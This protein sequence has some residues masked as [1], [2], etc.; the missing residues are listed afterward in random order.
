MKVGINITDLVPGKI[1]GMETYIRAL[2]H[3]FP[4]I[5]NED[6]F[7]VVGYKET[8]RTIDLNG[9]K[10]IPIKKPTTSEIRSKLL[11][12]I[13]IKNKFD[14]WFSPLLI[15]D[16]LDC[17]IPSVIKI[18]DMQHEYY[19]DFFSP[20]L[21]K[22]R[23]RY[24]QMSADNA[25]MILTV[26][27]KSRDDILKY[28][29]VNPKKVKIT[30]QNSPQWF[31]N[32]ISLNQMKL[33]KRNYKLPDQ[34]LFYPANS[35]KH[36]NHLRLLKAFSSVKNQV[37]KVHLV[38]S[39][40][41]QEAFDEIKLSIKKNNLTDRVHLLGYIDKKDI[42]GIYKNAMG[43]IFPSL[44]EG[45]GIP[46]V[47]AF[48]VGCPVLCANNTSM[49]EIAGDAALYFDASSTKS[50]A[51]TLVQFI[52]HKALREN[53]ILRGYKQSKKF[54][55]KKTAQETI[56]YFHEIAVKRVNEKITDWPKISIITPS[57]NQGCFIEETIKSVLDQKYPNLEYIVMDGGSTD[58]TLSILKKYDKKLQWFSKKDKGQTDAIN[59]GLK[60]AKGEIIAYLNSDDTYESGTLEK[61]AKI[62][63]KNPNYKF[64]YGK[65]KHIDK[66]GKFIGDYHNDY[67]D[68][69]ALQPTC[70]I[71][72]PAAF[73][74]KELSHT[75]GLFDT[76]HDYAMD[77]DYWIRTAKKYRMVY[78]H[79]Y[80]AN[81]RLHDETKTLGQ[82]RKVI[83][84]CIKLELKNYKFVHYEWIL[85]LAN[86]DVE[87]YSQGKL[88]ER[89]Y[90]RFYLIVKSFYY[91]ISI[92]K[93]WPP[94]ILI[95]Y[96]LIW[97]RDIFLDI[98][99][100]L[101]AKSVHILTLRKYQ[102][103][104]VFNHHIPKEKFKEK[105][106][107]FTTKKFCKISIVTP[108]YNQGQF[109]EKTIK[110][111]LD[112]RYPNLEYVV[113]DGASTDNTKEILEKYRGK[114]TFESKKNQGKSQA[115][116]LGF[117][118]TSGEIMA[119]LNSS[120]MYCEGSF[121][122]INDYFQ[123]HPDVDVVYGF[124]LTIDENDNQIGRLILY[125]HD[126]RVLRFTNYIPQETIFWRRRVWD[127]VKGVDESFNLAT[128][129][130][131]II[132][133]IESGAKFA[134][135]PYFL[136]MSRY[137]LDQKKLAKI[138]LLKA[139]EFDK[140]LYRQHKR[141]ITNIEVE[142]LNATYRNK[143]AIISWLF[144][145]GIRI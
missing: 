57:Y 117:K 92:N 142:K 69:E 24:Y 35:W 67:V 106:P 103:F 122:F 99:N 123:K 45:F 52:N 55:F 42:Q 136:G 108:T 29:D 61:V 3:F 48:R 77:Y 16:P 114:I 53:L 22:W 11:R 130:D 38:F 12:K 74:R 124:R 83:E 10:Q 36:K 60:M 37:P 14:V 40:Y 19:P 73:W 87:K 82:K 134:R 125:R 62:F 120:D 64:I 84:D 6:T 26:S 115:I 39:G 23:K 51:D 56:R 91:Y 140:I 141:N 79:D 41:P 30:Y 81:S 31:D 97:F 137:Y 143:S 112:Q 34:Y 20:E 126:P 113:Q 59:K 66:N 9:C 128:N 47:E 129:W 78:I 72:Q 17:P 101:K 94:K 15:L 116:N 5:S 80:F 21:L 132:R 86:D 4:L 90:F 13:I 107:K 95:K 65:G 68:L 105:F 71:C 27:K 33:I 118:K 2:I 7:Y 1:G 102:E 144:D 96:Y 18:P 98:R 58:E 50:I 25:D 43:L 135:L 138:N 121:N 127:K 46:I 110:S 54:S 88:V 76:A 139:K 89:I 28:L 131:L 100:V 44:F 119:Y 49:P 133:F 70:D 104:G 109:L 63:K 75:V 145:L 111:V 93:K 8:L 85:S 32:E